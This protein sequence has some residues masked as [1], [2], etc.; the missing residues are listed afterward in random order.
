[1]IVTCPTSAN[2]TLKI[3]A[4]VDGSDL[5]KITAQQ[6]EWTHRTYSEPHEVRLNEVVWDLSRTNVLMNS[7]MNSFLPTGIDFSTARIVRRKGRDLATMWADADAVWVNFADNPNGSDD[8]E[9]EL[10]F[11]K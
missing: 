11:G 5:F 3:A 2:A 6:A 10:S 9:L 7:G 4:H 8:Y 1:M